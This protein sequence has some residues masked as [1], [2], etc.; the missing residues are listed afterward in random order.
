MPAVIFNGAKTKNLKDELQLLT[1]SSVISRAVD[2]TSVATAGEPGSLLMNPST[3]VL[4]KKLDSGTTTNWEIQAAS[5]S[6]DQSYE[7][8]NLGLAASVAGN[9]LTIEVKDKSGA[10]PSGGSLVKV[11]FRSGTLTSG[12]YST[13]NISSALSMVVAN[14]SSLGQADGINMYVYVYLL[15]NAGTAELAVSTSYF[16]DGT[17]HSTTA[18]GGGTATANDTLYSTTA[19]SNVATRLIGRLKVN[20]ATAGVWASAPSEISIM[21]FD[22][23]PVYVKVDTSTSAV[24]AL[25]TVVYTNK[26]VD[27]RNAYNPATGIFTAPEAGNYRVTGFFQAG[28]H[29]AVA[30]DTVAMIINKNGSSSYVIGVLQWQTIATIRAE[31]LGTGSEN[32]IVTDTLKIVAN[33]T[34]GATLT[35]NGT[36]ATNWLEIV[37]I[38]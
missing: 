28:T 7:L 11:G 27:T 22:V 15:N 23:E 3:A 32:C 10:N 17:T 38:S 31:A 33:N 20:E 29:S 12:N 21:P 19:R 2:P 8:S 24:A 34:F 30:T 5:A 13:V 18:E 1:G 36:P 14:G 9:D 6:A 35:M 25:G 16:E 37:K 4:Y 26:I